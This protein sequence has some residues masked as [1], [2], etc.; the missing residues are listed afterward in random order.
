MTKSQI[1]IN[2]IRLSQE[3]I[4]VR[5]YYSSGDS[6]HRK[7][8]YQAIAEDKVNISC[9]GLESG[10][11]GTSVFCCIDKDPYKKSEK[12]TDKESDKKLNKKPGEKYSRKYPD[13]DGRAALEYEKISKVCTISVYPH[14]SSLNT[15]GFLIQL[16]AQKKIMFQ[17]MVSSNSMISFVIEMSDQK[18][19]LNL[20]EKEFDLPP[21]HTPF[22]QDYHDQTCE[23]VK[24]RYNETRA[25]YIEQ[26]IKTY[27]IGLT[28]CLDL[29]EI[30][31]RPDQL[32][33]C[34]KGIK[35]LEKTGKKFYFTC[36]MTH[37]RDGNTCHL[38]CLTDPL[39]AFDR[40]SFLWELKA[41]K[42][43]DVCKFV[44][45]DLI[46]FQGPHFGDRFGIFNAA[47]ACFQSE[48]IPV[49]LAGCTGA[50]ICMVLPSPMGEIATPALAKGFDT[51]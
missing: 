42:S 20:L 8:I 26:K 1:R 29:L 34:G 5:E 31:C 11:D 50:S 17:H 19:V 33:T 27:G 7:P 37:N 30:C 4:Q 40:Q 47:M 10:I 32:E 18:R 22:Q 35:F 49:L 9:L 41:E 38:F 23:F 2:G 15:L 3:M 21:T 24:N 13:Q 6:G 45:A 14:H 39:S 12:K 48:S 46:S 44:S 25:T 28:P 36:A 43:L 16:L 51:P